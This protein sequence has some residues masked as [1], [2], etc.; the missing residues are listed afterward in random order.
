MFKTSFITLATCLSFIFTQVAWANEDTHSL[1]SI[2]KKFVEDFHY[3]LSDYNQNLD[4]Q[5][6]RITR[7][8]NS[9]YYVLKANKTVAKFSAT[10][11]LQNRLYINNKLVAWTSALE[12]KTKHNAEEKTSFINNFLITSVHAYDEAVLDFSDLNIS[13]EDTKILVASLGKLTKN[14]EEAGLTCFTQCKKNTRKANLA[15]LTIGV[16]RQIADCQ[17]QVDKQSESIQSAKTHKMSSLLYSVYDPEF[18]GMK[19]FI[20][21]TSKTTK[22]KADSFFEDFLGHEDKK[23][24]N[25]PSTIASMTIADNIDR[26]MGDTIARGAAAFGSTTVEINQIKNESIKFCQKLQELKEC[27][28]SVNENVTIMNSVK[29]DIKRTTGHD[30]KPES[31][32]SSNVLSK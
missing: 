23:Y 32:P 22:K 24:S 4:K 16:N 12:L 8:E 21:E 17:G 25:C 19:K 30:A 10:D 27:A 28:A 9:A 29:R 6:A 5:S 7:E 1:D 11:Y 15:K 14:L 31:L 3:A 13:V 18:I 26:G 20:E 2:S